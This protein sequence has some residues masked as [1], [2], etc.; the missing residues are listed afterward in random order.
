[1]I[2]DVEYDKDELPDSE[3][4]KASARV[5]NKIDNGKDGFLP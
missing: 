2:E 3:F 1:M 5:F 4:S